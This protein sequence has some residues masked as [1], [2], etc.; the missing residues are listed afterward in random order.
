MPTDRF[1]RMQEAILRFRDERDWEPFHQPK[2]LALG[3]GIEAAE[4]GELF[5]WK[6]RDACDEALR[7]PGF[8]ERLADEIADV[9]VFLVYLAHHTGIDIHDAVCAKL[10]KNAAKYP[11]A[12]ARGSAR[13]YTEL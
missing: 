8:R 3:L 5:L 4:V 2:D 12:K 11:V 6:D 10:V 1:E 7:D 13:K 9:Q